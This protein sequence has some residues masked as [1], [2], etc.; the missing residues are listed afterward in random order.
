MISM[1]EYLENI[2]VD[3]ASDI[4]EQT[5]LWQ[6]KG[7]NFAAGC[8]PDY[9]NLQIQRLYL[10][11]YSFAYG[12]EYS[13]IYSEVLA[14]LHNPQK[15]CVVSIGCGN[16]LDYWSLVQSI[17]KKN[18]ECE[19]RYVG[20]DEIDW[21]YKFDKRDGD[22]L[23]FKKGNAINFFEENKEFISDI[24][25]FPK[26]ISEF[27]AK[28][29]N[30]MVNNLQN[31][32]ILR[33][34]LIFCFSIRANEGSR[35]RDMEKTEQIIGALKRNGFHLINPTYGYTFYRENKGIIAY[36]NS[37]VYPQEAYDYIVSLN[38]KCGSYIKNGA[39][40]GEDCIQYLNRKPTTKTGNIYYR[41]IELERN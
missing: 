6:L 18:L 36:D 34:K 2:Y 35:E 19:V 4:N 25:F 11:R 37:Y 31:K 8:L 5:K 14:R 29:M 3:F 17:E 40:C 16:F 22:E 21:N 26:S 33:D 1:S 10:L 30:V 24:Y 12:F 23:Y 32:P 38:E 28:E 41:I 27:D 7:L 20:I 13:G 9:N 15:V 39:N